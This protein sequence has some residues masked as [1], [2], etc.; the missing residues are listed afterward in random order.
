[1]PDSCKCKWKSAL[2][3]DEAAAHFMTMTLLPRALNP[4]SRLTFAHCHGSV[5]RSSLCMPRL[6]YEDSCRA[7]QKSGLLAPGQIPPVRYE[8]PR[9]NDTEPGVSLFRS[10]VAEVK[11]ERLT[12]PRTFIS[13]SEFRA[14][15]FKD[16][17][18]SGSTVNWNDFIGVKFTGA[19]LSGVDFRAC[20]FNGVKFAKANLAGADFRYC[21]FTKCDFS[22]AE[23][24]DAKFTQKTGRS[25][26]LSPEQLAVIDWQSEDGEEPEGG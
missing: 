25:L 12:L 19:D 22:G 8:R 6:S 9:H 18:L 14:C 7:L 24:A 11:L 20:V 3:T 4:T 15:S 16:T 17:D 2:H 23:L 5:Q 10:L 21:G 1:M 13:R 26:R